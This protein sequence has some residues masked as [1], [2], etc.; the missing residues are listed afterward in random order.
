MYSSALGWNGIMRE[1]VVGLPI[2]LLK[3]LRR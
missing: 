1:H 3:S 2:H